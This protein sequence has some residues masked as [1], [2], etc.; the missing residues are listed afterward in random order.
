MATGLK[1]L[2][3]LGNQA[4]HGAMVSKDAASWA[5]EIAPQLLAL[6]STLRSKAVKPIVIRGEI[7]NSQILGAFETKTPIPVRY[8]RPF[9]IPPNVSVRF[10]GLGDD[11]T[12]SRA[13]QVVDADEKGFSV[14]VVTMPATHSVSVWTVKWKATGPTAITGG[15]YEAV[16]VTG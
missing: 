3:I 1:E 15:S 11:E 4:A 10:Y 14:N 16:R 7:L 5:L 2:I 12:I 9:A 13:L 6:L 8:P